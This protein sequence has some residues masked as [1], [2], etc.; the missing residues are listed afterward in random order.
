[1]ILADELIRVSTATVFASCI[2]LYLVEILRG[3]PLPQHNE[4][5]SRHA[6]LPRYGYTEY[7]QSFTM[8]ANQHV[9]VIL[10]QI[11]NEAGRIRHHQREQQTLG[12]LTEQ[13]RDG[14]EKERRGGRSKVR[15]HSD[16]GRS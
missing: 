8:Y 1:V 3:L 14:R 6:N 4:R 13:S 9:G 5:I 11:H 12:D 15:G 2:V 10:R 7:W 16:R